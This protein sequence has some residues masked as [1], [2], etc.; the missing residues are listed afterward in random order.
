MNQFVKGMGGLDME[1][2]ALL[3]KPF[4]EFNGSQEMFGMGLAYVRVLGPDNI[5]MAYRDVAERKAHYKRKWDAQV[6]E[7]WKWKYPIHCEEGG[8]VTRGEVDRLFK[9]GNLEEYAGEGLNEIIWN[10]CKSFIDASEAVDQDWY[11]YL[12][13]FMKGI[14]NALAIETRAREILQLGA[15]RKINGEKV[16]T[17]KTA[18]HFLDLSTLHPLL[19]KHVPTAATGPGSIYINYLEAQSIRNGDTKKKV[20]D[21]LFNAMSAKIGKAVAVKVTE[22]EKPEVGF[23]VLARA[24]SGLTSRFTVMQFA[25]LPALIAVAAVGMK[26]FVHNGVPC[27]IVGVNMTDPRHAAMIKQACK[28]GSIYMPN[29]FSGLIPRCLMEYSDGVQKGALA[30]S[31]EPFMV[32]IIEN[33]EAR[34]DKTTTGQNTGYNPSGGANCSLATMTNAQAYLTKMATATA[35]TESQMDKSM[36]D[37]REKQSDNNLEYVWSNN[38]YNK[39]TIK[40]N[41]E[42]FFVTVDT[43]GAAQ[44]AGRKRKLDAPSGMLVE[45]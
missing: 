5:K 6:K 27:S 23:R 29:E 45:A 19:V 20:S 13:V 2:W 42:K 44:I 18:P 10:A 7:S 35:A 34:A 41:W 39:M 15:R 31:A 21:S 40:C 43:N 25:D 30:A 33:V 12:R 36:K 4:G 8:S 32:P 1:N 9:S 37:R 24:A 17:G 22:A 38:L 16:R 3:I 14:V 11:K 26:G 28:T